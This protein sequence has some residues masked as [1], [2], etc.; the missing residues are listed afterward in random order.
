MQNKIRYFELL[1]AFDYIG[2]FVKSDFFFSEKTYVT[3][4]V[5]N[6]FWATILYKY[7]GLNGRE[8]TW[9]THFYIHGYLIAHG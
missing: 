3:P 7:H 4:Y 1:N 8:T 5:R 6:M 2:R 9:Y